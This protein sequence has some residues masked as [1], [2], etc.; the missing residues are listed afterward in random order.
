M[1]PFLIA[2]AQ[3]S[4]LKDT[5]SVTIIANCR[6]N[7]RLRF[8]P[9]PG[10][11]G[12]RSILSL[13]SGVYAVAPTAL[14]PQT[15]LVGWVLATTVFLGGC[16]LF[17]SPP[18]FSPGEIPYEEPEFEHRRGEG[19]LCEQVVVAVLNS[20]GEYLLSMCV[21][22]P[23]SPVNLTSPPPMGGKRVFG[24]GSYDWLDQ[25]IERRWQ[26]I[27]YAVVTECFQRLSL[28]EGRGYGLNWTLQADARDGGESAWENA[29][30]AVR[31]QGGISSGE[32]LEQKFFYFD[33]ETAT[34]FFRFEYLGHPDDQFILHDPSR[35]EGEAY[36]SMSQWVREHDPPVQL[37]I[38]HQAYIEQMEMKLLGKLLDL[39]VK[40]LE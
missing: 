19:N 16:G 29:V 30:R 12:F 38:A 21:R 24:Q 34:G 17:D 11:P 2:N 27:A 22:Q 15:L 26:S 39:K 31:E 6:N 33:E 32:S 40:T 18:P 5:G 13:H 14:F 36:C 4:R 9:R 20:N 10:F 23:G 37:L 8:F 25:I 7:T 35:A 28:P 1:K 3:R